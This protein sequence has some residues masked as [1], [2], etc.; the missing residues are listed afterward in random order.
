M[1]NKIKENW[2]KV[3]MYICF[4]YFGIS[5]EFVYI[6]L[7]PLFNNSH[8]YALPPP[9]FVYDTIYKTSPSYIWYIV[10]ITF[11]GSL[12]S[13]I[14]GINLYNIIKN[15]DNKIVSDNWINNITN[16]TDKKIINLL[17]E[18]NNIMTQSQIVKESGMTKVKIH[19][20]IQKLES[21]KIIEK[22]RYGQTN[23]I[24][25]IKNKTKII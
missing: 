3:L 23:K 20:I 5:F 7:L 11:L 21:Y 25:L 17:K 1:I 4:I 15:K 16:E 24:R 2:N 10:I 9:P 19:R 14:C 22:F 13:L 12:I 8:N 6:Q 18:K